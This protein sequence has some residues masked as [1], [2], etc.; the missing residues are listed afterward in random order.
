M[1]L[2]RISS[3][4]R[5]KAAN[6]RRARRPHALLASAA[7]SSLLAVAA[8]VAANAQQPAAIPVSSPTA[9]PIEPASQTF[10]NEDWAKERT[11]RIRAILDDADLLGKT[12]VLFIG[13]S[14]TQFWTTAGLPVWTRTF[15]GARAPIP[16]IDLGF[17]GD[18]TENLLMHITPRAAGGT[19]YL[20]DPAL[21]PEVIVLMIGINNTWKT[22]G[23]VVENVIAGNIAIISRL[24][25][26]RPNARLIVQSLLPA[27]DPA[28]TRN[29]VVPINQALQRTVEGL[30][31]KVEWLDVY[32][33]FVDA[34]G[35]PAAELFPDKVHP[36]LKGYEI[37][38][39]VLVNALKGAEHAK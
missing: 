28:H 15:D 26:M 11:A 21:S 19:G 10:A 5:N 27:Q 25:Q 38:S 30:G 20:D 34:Q 2:S 13:D 18:R 37:W 6:P 23:P 14:I 29:F 8:P 3:F 9:S 33:L 31:P 16:S 1:T 32:P 39:Q 24:R 35:G 7:C 4:L 22:Q 17:A 36:A 12:R